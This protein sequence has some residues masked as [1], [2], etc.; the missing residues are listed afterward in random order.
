[1]RDHET[2]IQQAGATVAAVGLGDQRYASIFK[3]QTGITFPLLVDDR[4]QAY[5]VAGLKM[6]SMLHL[7]RSD[8]LA[9]RNRAAAG[10]HRQRRL[11]KNPFQLGGS[12]V[13][14]PGNV[15]R[16]AH[17][18]QTFGDNAEPVDLIAAVNR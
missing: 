12:F 6:G 11:G 4:R 14:G 8:N 3:R 17:I 7:M 15:D 5:K 13:F 1:M 2:E 10:G 18:S 16:F 9:A